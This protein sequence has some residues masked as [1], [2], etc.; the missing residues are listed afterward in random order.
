LSSTQKGAERRRRLGRDLPG[1]AARAKREKKKNEY[2]PRKTNSKT[3]G[4][5]E[6]KKEGRLE[7][8][9][10][11]PTRSPD[12][13]GRRMQQQGPLLGETLATKRG[14]KM[15]NGATGD[16]RKGDERVSAYEIARRREG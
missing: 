16:G 13:S 10:S 1:T 5:R 8:T 9:C 2:R 7:G 14:R 4:R 3:G 12:Y 15:P 6:R 11:T